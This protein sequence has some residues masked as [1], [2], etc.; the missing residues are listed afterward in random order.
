MPR[1]PK[2][3][4]VDAEVRMLLDKA[5]NKTIA[6]QMKQSQAKNKQQT[7]AVRPMNRTR[8]CNKHRSMLPVSANTDAGTAATSSTNQLPDTCGDLNVI[9]DDLDQ[10]VKSLQQELASVQSAQQQVLLMK[11]KHRLTE[12][13]QQQMQEQEQALQEKLEADVCQLIEHRNSALCICQE[14]AA[15]LQA[16]MDQLQDMLQHTLQQQQHIQQ[17]YATCMDELKQ[18]FATSLASRQKLLEQ[19]VKQQ[20]QQFSVTKAS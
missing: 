13:M 18:R 15:K 11:E 2:H 17:T 1:A 10:Q 5:P 20:L 19:S 7:V 6:T 16:G 12:W 4:E 14:H 3:M 8:P 9:S